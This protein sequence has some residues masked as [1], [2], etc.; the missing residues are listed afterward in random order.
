MGQPA[1]EGPSP[2]DDPKAAWAATR[3]AVIA[4]LEDPAVATLEFEGRS[5]PQTFERSVAQFLCTDLLVHGWDV[6]RATGQDERIDPD[7]AAALLA[8]V[9]PMDEMMRAPGAFGP[10]IEPPAGADVQTRLL[11]FLG[12]PV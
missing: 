10:K 8:A 5:G 4:G 6:A 1:P 9:E 7:E 11:N 2:D 12:R 3:D